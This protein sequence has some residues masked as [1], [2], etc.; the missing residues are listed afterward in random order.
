MNLYVSYKSIKLYK[1]KTESLCKTVKHL[2]PHFIDLLGGKDK[3]G[4]RLEDGTRLIE[5]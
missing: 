3:R 1:T 5:L 2:F 4:M